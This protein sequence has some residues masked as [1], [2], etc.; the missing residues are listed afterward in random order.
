LPAQSQYHNFSQWPQRTGGCYGNA[1]L[2]LSA[3]ATEDL[4]S[5]FTDARTIHYSP[6]LGLNKDRY[7]CRRLLRWPDYIDYSPLA[8]EAW[9]AQERILAPR[10]VHFTKHQM[11]WEYGERLKYEASGILDTESLNHF[12]STLP[13]APRLSPAIYLPPFPKQKQ[14]SRVAKVFRP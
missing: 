14:N 8:R 10:I 7:L 12:S 11:I 2:M 6:A 9:A 3:I 1:T 5:R 4:N 13:S